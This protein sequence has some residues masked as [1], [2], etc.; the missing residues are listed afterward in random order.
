MNNDERTVL[1][2]WQNQT[3]DG[4]RMTPEEIEMRLERL[5]AKMRARTRGGYLVAAFLTVWFAVMAY[6]ESDPFLRVGAIA[7]VGSA[8]YIAW[9][10]RQSRFR[11]PVAV[12]VPTA[13]IDHLR[14][15]L[16]RQRDFHLGRRFWSRMLFLSAAGV[17]FFYGFA[18]AHPEVIRII[19]FEIASFIVFALAAI[20]LNLW[21]AR[22][23]QRQIDDLDRQKEPS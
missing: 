20:P 1:A 13:S 14:N 5:D 4:F 22:K 19:R 15:E 17:V 3:G 6:L 12:A 9:Q 21:M 10:L 18:R 7:V 11:R 2:L 23:Y 16:Q 8:L